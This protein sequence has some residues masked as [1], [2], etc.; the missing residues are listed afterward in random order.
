ML[1]I[2]KKIIPLCCVV[3]LSGCSVYLASAYGNSG[4][5][6]QTLTA[7]VGMGKKCLQ[8]KR[9][10]LIHSAERKGKYVETYKGINPQADLGYVRALVYTYLD[11][12]T[13]LYWEAVGT[14]IETA[15]IVHQKY[16]LADVTY[17]NKKSDTIERIDVYE[18]TF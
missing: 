10:V 13:G 14:S 12:I 4:I 1:R 8:E 9:I 11:I 3:L 16:L 6:K 17:K 15:L 2:M 5:N 18:E 7:C